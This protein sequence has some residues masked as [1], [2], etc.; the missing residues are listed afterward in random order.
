LPYNL[1]SIVYRFSFLLICCCLGLS[2]P[3]PSAAADAGSP[4]TPGQ[5]DDVLLDGLRALIAPKSETTLSSPMAGRINTISVHQG[6]H[7]EQNQVLV[8]FDCEIQTAQKKKANAKLIAVRQMHGSGL[9]LQQLGSISDVDLAEA[10][11]EL[12]IAEADLAIARTQFSHCTLRAPFSGHVAALEVSPF[13][14]V[15]QNQPLMTILDTS[16]LEIHTYVP[17]MWLTWLKRNT[18]FTIYIEETQRTYEATVRALAP[19]IDPA[20]HSIEII[21]EFIQD[22]PDLLSGMS[23]LITFPGMQDGAEQ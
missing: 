13:E 2:Q 19:Q 9:E 23:G 6:D 18:R 17:S 8:R 3:Q 15:A 7:F 14:T 5:H 10:E 4:D 21:G 16:E 11:A 20:S 22:N 1:P 12:K